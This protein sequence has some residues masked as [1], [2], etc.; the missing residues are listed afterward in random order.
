MTCKLGHWS[1]SSYETFLGPMQTLFEEFWPFL[2][3]QSD[4]FA[5]V[6]S[7]KNDKKSNFDSNFH[8]LS[9]KKYLQTYYT[10]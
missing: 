2:H 7:S 5:H 9:G 8:S 3:G 4:N 10:L 1:Y 6:K